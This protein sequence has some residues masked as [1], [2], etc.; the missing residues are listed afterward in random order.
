MKMTTDE[1]NEKGNDDRFEIIKKAKEKLIESTNIDTSPAEMAV[2]D[3]FLFRCWQMGWLSSIKETT[4]CGI[5]IEEVV[6]I[7]NGIELERR[8]DLKLT[9]ENLSKWQEIIRKDYEYNIKKAFDEQME[10]NKAC[11]E[12]SDE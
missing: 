11:E 12:P 2:I 3:N 4:I 5:P 10:L 8:Y 9:M 7:L 6:K 1:A